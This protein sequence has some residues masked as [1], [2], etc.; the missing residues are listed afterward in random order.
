MKIAAETSSFIPFRAETIRG[1]AMS[2][3]R[4][5]DNTRTIGMENK[6]GDNRMMTA[7]PFTNRKLRWLRGED[8]NL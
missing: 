6:K 3:G 2:I 7:N 8:L 4:N 1:K 5:T